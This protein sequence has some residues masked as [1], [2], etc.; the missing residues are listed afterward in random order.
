MNN[1][2]LSSFNSHCLDNLLKCPFDL[3]TQNNGVR[4][5]ITHALKFSAQNLS[6][7]FRFLS[8]SP[9]QG[10]YNSAPPRAPSPA[11]VLLFPFPRPPAFLNSAVGRSCFLHLPASFFCVCATSAALTAVGLFMRCPRCLRSHIASQMFA[12]R[13]E[14]ASGV[15]PSR[16]SVSRKTIRSNFLWIWVQSTEANWRN[17]SSGRAV[18]RRKK[19]KVCLLCPRRSVNSA[20]Q[21]AFMPA[22]VYFYKGIFYGGCARLSYM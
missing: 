11:L 9:F 12:P 17:K 4:A 10:I 13:G 2:F 18:A 1:W 6:P 8:T 22:F 20:V 19:E 14:S 16:C 3:T 5:S 7:P 15:G 21:N